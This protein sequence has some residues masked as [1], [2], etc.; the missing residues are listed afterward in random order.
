MQCLLTTPV[1]LLT[2]NRPNVTL[3]VLKAIREVAPARLYLA[4]DGPRKPEESIVVDQVRTKVTSGIDWDCDVKTLFRDKNLG[5]RNAVNS[6]IT[7][8]FDNE[9]RGIILE[10]DCLPHK[11]FFLFC[12]ALLE[13]YALDETIWTI[14]GDNFHRDEGSKKNSYY[15][16]KYFHYWVRPLLVSIR[17]R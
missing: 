13:K 9:E 5:C 12:E 17:T 2:F 16:S 6:A 10:D 3:R 11:T 8:F 4:S 15:F 1:L 14:S 7:W